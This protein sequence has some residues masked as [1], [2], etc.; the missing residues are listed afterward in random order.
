[1]KEN[2]RVVVD[3]TI[4]HGRAHFNLSYPKEQHTL[5]LSQIRSILSG[6]VALTIR[7]SENEPQAMKEVINYLEYEFISTDSFDDISIEVKD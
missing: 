2:Y 6:A 7:G 5:N 1:M 3:M 4:E